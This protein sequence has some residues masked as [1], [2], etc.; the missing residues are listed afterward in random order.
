MCKKHIFIQLPAQQD[1]V[2]GLNEMSSAV[3]DERLLK[4]M[5]LPGQR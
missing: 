4:Q 3:P 5:S 2:P 1:S